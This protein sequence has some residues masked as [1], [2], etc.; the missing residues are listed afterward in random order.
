[1]N[2]RELLTRMSMGGATALAWGS[3]L[4]SDRTA[5]ASQ[6]ADLT[7]LGLP[8]VT[9]SVSETGYQ[10]VPATT[11]AGWTLVTFENQ[12]PG[13]NSADIMLLPP[14]E[15]M[16]SLL[17]VVSAAV[18][19]PAAVPP[20]WI[21]QTTFAG[22]PWAQSGTSEQAVVLLSAG[23]WV[24]FSPAPL[25]PAT[26]TVT[27]ESATPAGSPK[28]Q[29]DREVLMQEYAFLGFEEP[30]PAGPQ[31]WQITNQGQQPHFVTVS[32]LPP[33][34]TQTQY[35][36]TLMAM[37]SGTPEAAGPDMG[38]PSIVGGCSTLSHGQSLYLELDLEAGTYGA[39]CFFPEPG[40]G[41]PHAMMGMAQVFTAG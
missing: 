41:A 32:P 6:R 30:V 20:A 36:D 34:T 8:E 3:P 18:E 10:A 33:G 26:L 27:G 22:A 25:T 12:G 11:P 29:I 4:F 38:A 1:M 35:M 17:E 24:V 16:E 40:T 28:L 21:Y 37:M 2:R 31:V 23:E 39:I 19:S 9:I 5:V 15:T 13:D 7:A 14:G